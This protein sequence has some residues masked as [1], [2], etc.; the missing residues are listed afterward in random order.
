MLSGQKGKAIKPLNAEMR[1]LANMR[2][3]S[4]RICLVLEREE[5]RLVMDKNLLKQE[6][7]ICSLCKEESNHSFLRDCIDGKRHCPKCH[8][9]SFSS[10][11]TFDSYLFDISEKHLLIDCICLKYY[12]L[13]NNFYFKFYVCIV[14]NHFSV[15]VPISKI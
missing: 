8:L 12:V 9:T 15:L 1:P 14:Y 3:A 10:L 7:R 5:F 6:N 4:D 2:N 13:L 11:R